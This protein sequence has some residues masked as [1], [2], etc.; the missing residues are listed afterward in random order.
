MLFRSVTTF[1][2]LGVATSRLP[3]ARAAIKSSLRPASLD[4]TLFAIISLPFHFDNT[5][6]LAI[7]VWPDLN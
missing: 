4:L 2:L 1:V 3:N 5:A 7:V 6:L